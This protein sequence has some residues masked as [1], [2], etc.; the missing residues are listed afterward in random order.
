[1]HSN[2]NSIAK[3]EGIGSEHNWR[4]PLVPG[5]R[6]QAPGYSLLATYFSLLCLGLVNS[7]IECTRGKPSRT[8]AL[9]LPSPAN[10]FLRAKTVEDDCSTLLSPLATR[11][12][13]LFCSPRPASG[14]GAGGEG[15]GTFP[16][17]RITWYTK[18]SIPPPMQESIAM[19]IMH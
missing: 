9:H 6:L 14:R 15:L 3:P 10:Y 12:P 19:L 17:H 5:S 18:D 8:T 1:M 7:P 16:N 4:S 2:A 13:P 11:F